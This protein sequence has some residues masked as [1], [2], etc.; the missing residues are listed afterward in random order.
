V[1]IVDH[2]LG[3]DTF[4]TVSDATNPQVTV[5]HI[6]LVQDNDLRELREET[7]EEEE[8]PTDKARPTA[9]QYPVVDCRPEWN[10]FVFH[11]CGPQLFKRYLHFHALKLFC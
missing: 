3:E 9:F 10:A 5:L 8:E 4:L 7:L 6:I 1:V 11:A 2:A